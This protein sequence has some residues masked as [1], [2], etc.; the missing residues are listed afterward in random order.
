MVSSVYLRLLV[1]LLAILI[2]AWVTSGH[3]TQRVQPHPL[4]DNWIQ[5][6]R[7][8]ALPTRPR[9]SFSNHQSVPSG[10]LH[11]LLC[12]I[13]QKSDRRNKESYHH[14]ATWMKTTSWKVNQNGK[15]EDYVPNKEKDKTPGKKLNKNKI[16]SLWEKE[17][18]IMIMKMIQGLG[19]IKS[20]RKWKKCLPNT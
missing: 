9:P 17:F 1:F 13:H 2:P 6:L 5:V 20:W 3:T 7:S 8:T 15:A 18:R 10:S 14:A 4:A 12:L 16:G 19:G 11:K